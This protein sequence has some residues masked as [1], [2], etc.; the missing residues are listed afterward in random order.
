[1][2]NT[3]QGAT[4]VVDAADVLT[5]IDK[6]EVLA[7]QA[8][9]YANI[10]VLATKSDAGKE[11]DGV[12]ATNKADVE[13]DIKEA[14][15]LNFVG[16]VRVWNAAMTADVIKAMRGYGESLVVLSGR[17]ADIAGVDLGDMAVW[18]TETAA[19]TSM[20]DMVA[21]SNRGVMLDPTKQGKL[22]YALSSL[23]QDPNSMEFTNQITS[24]TFTGITDPEIANALDE[25]GYSY[26]FRA[27]DKIWLRGF[28]M[29][30]QQARSMYADRSVEYDVRQA[31]SMTVNS[32]MNYNEGNM[33]LLEAKILSALRDNAF[34]VN[35]LKVN[36]PRNQKASS[37]VRGIV[38]DVRVKYETAQ[39]VR[40]V[41]I[42]MGGNV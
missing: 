39:E 5:K 7:P 1:M 2:I 13:A 29:G 12:L 21:L 41:V 24:A 14:D 15:E 26:W 19:Q 20:D 30:K 23:L 9:R 37:K 25:A 33:A 31:V 11:L 36:V 4:G 8:K 6:E 18:L 28:W 38:Y 17:T 3:S 34:V 42:K 27:T 22:L 35:V 40:T 32:G 10:C 16:S